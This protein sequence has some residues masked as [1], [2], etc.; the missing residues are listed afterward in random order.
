MSFWANAWNVAHMTAQHFCHC[1]EQLLKT[2]LMLFFLSFFFGWNLKEIWRDP[3]GG[4]GGGGGGWGGGGGGGWGL[5]SLWYCW[6]P[7]YH[8]S[9]L[10]CFGSHEG[11]SLNCPKT[12][13]GWRLFPPLSAG[14]Q[15]TRAIYRTSRGA[16]TSN[17]LLVNIFYY[18]YYE[19][20]L[21]LPLKKKVLFR[22]QFITVCVYFFFFFYGCMSWDFRRGGLCV[23]WR[24]K[25]VAYRSAQGFLTGYNQPGLKETFRLKFRAEVIADT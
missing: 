16:K 21:F 20:F 6:W 17:N 10:Q 25:A 2:H 22:F 18:Y 13:P 9:A 19:R 7:I 14:R 15:D 24:I 11:G 3:V 5:S 8:I 12:A 4:G 1:R 23:V